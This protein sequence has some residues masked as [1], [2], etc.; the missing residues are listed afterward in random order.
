VRLAFQL[1]NFIDDMIKD[2]RFTKV[3]SDLY[4]LVYLLLKLVLFLPVATTSVERV[5]SSMNIVK[6][7]IK[8]F[9]VV[10]RCIVM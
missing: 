4:K 9:M 5:F 8:I 6:T 7:N 3:Q 1:D 10:R 2:D